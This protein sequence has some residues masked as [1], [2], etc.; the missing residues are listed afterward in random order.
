MH[1][2]SIETSCD[3]TAVSLVRADGDFP[4]ATYSILGNALF[5]QIDIPTLVL[6]G[7]ND[8]LTP[9]SMALEIHKL[10]KNSKLSIISDAGHLTNI[11][12]PKMFNDQVLKFL[13]KL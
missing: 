5:S 2:L 3:E 12:N 1:I 11:E 7:E 8:T 10:I 4:H 9:P 6:V 13:K